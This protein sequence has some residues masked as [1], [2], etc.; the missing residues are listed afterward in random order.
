MSL[1]SKHSLATDPSDDPP[2]SVSLLPRSCIGMIIDDPF[3]Q[4][5]SI[6]HVTHTW[7]PPLMGLAE[8]EAVVVVEVVGKRVEGVM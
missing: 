1:P 5:K 7:E 4:W 3:T 8:L 6:S 2:P